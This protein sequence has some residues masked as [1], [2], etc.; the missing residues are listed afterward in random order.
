MS[1]PDTIYVA[2]CFGQPQAFLSKDHRDALVAQWN[3]D[4]RGDTGLIL[5]TAEDW[6]E[7]K[8][9]GP[10]GMQAAW[11]R[12]PE[13]HFIHFQDLEMDTNGRSGSCRIGTVTS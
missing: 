4:H 7:E 3:G 9:H 10:G 2:V 1:A 8:W 6:P 5:A 13:R 11:G 12:M